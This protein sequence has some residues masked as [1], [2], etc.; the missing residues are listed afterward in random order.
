MRLDT[1]AMVDDAVADALE[2]FVSC[3]YKQKGSRT[4]EL[5]AL[6]WE[7]FKTSQAEADRLP[8]TKAALT[9]HI[10][11]A[12]Y[13]SIVW[14]H[15]EDANPIYPPPNQFGWKE[16]NDIFVPVI[17]TIEPAPKAVIELV[18]CNCQVSQCTARCTCR[19]ASLVC[20]ELCKC[21]L[22]DS[23]CENQPDSYPMM[24]LDSDSDED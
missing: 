1:S 14:A 9:Q 8:P 7:L 16:Q 20:T 22:H 15:L 19:K 11:R 12:A 10:L 24:Q 17:T 13:Q 6:R 3:L 4:K 2:E 18:R 23:S 21:S 5:A